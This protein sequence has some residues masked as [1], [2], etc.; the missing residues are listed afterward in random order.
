MVWDRKTGDYPPFGQN[1]QAPPPPLLPP[2]PLPTAFST[3][4]RTLRDKKPPE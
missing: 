3:G 1:R 2:L 4:E